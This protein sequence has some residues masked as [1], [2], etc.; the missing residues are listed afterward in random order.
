MQTT[1]RRCCPSGAILSL[2]AVI[3]WFFVWW[4]C[5]S[6]FL[7]RV[8]VQRSSYT[9]LTPVYFIFIFSKISFRQ[10]CSCRR[11]HDRC[12]SRPKRIIQKKPEV[13]FITLRALLS[14]FS[15]RADVWRVGVS[16]HVRWRL[17]SCNMSVFNFIN[18]LSSW[19]DFRRLNTAMFTWTAI[20]FNHFYYNFRLSPF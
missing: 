8:F 1:Q 15:D 12:S 5:N 17:V 11:V 14:L 7:C 20:S 10:H 19:M 4:C 2:Y 16:C 3:L 18:A 13:L 9:K 6:R